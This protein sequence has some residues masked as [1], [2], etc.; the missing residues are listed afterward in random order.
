[1][2]KLWGVKFFDSLFTILSRPH[3]ILNPNVCESVFI[4]RSH[5]DHHPQRRTSMN[6]SIRILLTILALNGL[7]SVRVLAGSETALITIHAELDREV[8]PANERQTAVVK[9]SLEAAPPPKD[10]KRAPVN[11]C[12]VLDRSGSMSG[13]KI[14]HAREAAL[15]AISRLGK[16]DVFSLITYNSTVE[17]L[18][19]AGKFDAR[20]AQEIIRSIQS[21]G[22]TALFGGVSQGAA[23]LRKFLEDHP[24]GM[25]HRMILMSDGL[26]N[27]GPS[28]P[29]DL[30]R[31]GASLMKEG[32]S[33][34]TVGLGNDYN[35]DLMTNLSQRSDGNTY[36][37]EN[38]NDLAR[39]FN[40][41]IGDVLSVV[42]RD[43]NIRIEC[44]QNI[45][46]LRTIGRDA[47]IR[48]QHVELKLNQLYG[49]Q[50]KFLLLEVEIP[51]SAVN[52]ELPILTA[53]VGYHNVFTQGNEEQTASAK[54]RFSDQ[55]SVVKN[56][57]NN[58]IQQA[59]FMNVSAL[60]KDEA[61]T[62]WESGDKAGA[63]KIL[64]ENQIQLEQAAAYYSLP[65][66]EKE[67][68]NL[69]GQRQDLDAEGLTKYNRKQMRTESLQESNQQRVKQRF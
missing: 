13:T 26:A 59:Y 33:V 5:K 3:D 45:R 38:S 9:I 56:S 64:A 22:N 11:L 68:D 17:T 35:E 40:E 67:A 30:G 54:A 18:I 14:A 12:I 34:T 58:D 51:A 43:V 46:P 27:V 66:L 48:G 39:I 15:E 4:E 65:V 8:L 23:E 37:V 69:E 52:I 41:E 36:F 20:R 16:D 57:V 49:N 32:I 42:A 19:P 28:S 61:I 1:M 29:E 60:A 62:R 53:H 6:T 21:S 10:A 55:E 50:E 2:L 31:L 44:P 25:V 24:Q 7:L 63:K 47:D